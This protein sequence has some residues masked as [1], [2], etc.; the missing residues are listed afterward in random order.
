MLTVAAEVHNPLLP[1]GTDI[2]WS[3]LF[4]AAAALVISALIQ[5][6]R[7]RALPVGA[8]LAW[9]VVVLA[10][11]LIGALAWLLFRSAL[12]RAAASR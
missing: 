7:T 12:Q 10:T 8:R 2:L 5:V 4:V 1:A 6:V 11:P 3:L 9:F